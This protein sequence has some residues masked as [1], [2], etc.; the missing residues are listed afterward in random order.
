M[1]STT[2]TRQP[3]WLRCEKKEFERRAALTPTTA[4]KLIDAGFD[5]T[6]ERDPQRIF[7]DE[8]YE[9]VG[10]K[11]VDNNTWPTA[12][13][14]IPIIG[15]K[16]LPVSTDPLPHTH[17]QFAHCYKNQAGWAA[18]LT[19]FA[20]GGGTLYDLE[21][22]QD[23][24]G[25]RVAAFGFHAGFA[26]AAA[27]AL[28]LAD[29]KTNSTSGPL[30]GLKLEPYNNEHEMVADVKEKLSKVKNADGSPYKPKA[31]VI[32]ALGRCGRGAVELF[33]KIGLEEDDIFKWDLPETAK[34]GPFEEILQV[35]MFINC[36][37]L[38]SSIP[39]F[40]T[41]DTIRAAGPNRRLSVIADVSCDTTNPFNP[42]PVYN[43]MTT[44]DAPTVEVDVGLLNLSPQ[45]P[46]T[47][48]SKTPV[49]SSLSPTMSAVILPPTPTIEIH[50][51][52]DEISQQ[53]EIKPLRSPY[54][55][56]S[57]SPMA[58]QNSDADDFRPLHLLPPPVVSP[59]KEH[60][61]SKPQSAGLPT[62]KKGIDQERFAQLL[63]S[64]RERA[65]MKHGRKESVE[66]RKQVTLKVHTTKAL[67]RRAL[68][69][70]KIQA[71]PNPEAA[72]S[73]VTPP[74]SPAIFHFTLPSPGMHSP[75]AMFEKLSSESDKGC[76][77]VNFPRDSSAPQDAKKGWVEEV[78][79][80]ARVRS[81]GMLRGSSA[82]ASL[83][84][85]VSARSAPRKPRGSSSHALPSL[86][87]ITARLAT[88]VA[89]HANAAPSDVAPSISAVGGLKPRPLSLVV[90][91]PRPSQ[92][93]HRRTPSSPLATSPVFTPN[94]KE[95]EEKT[96]EPESVPEI[97]VE[98][99]AAAPSRLPPFLQKRISRERIEV[100]SP[101]PAP[102]PTPAPVPAPAPAPETPTIQVTEPSPVQ[103]R[104]SQTLPSGSIVLQSP[105]VG[106]RRTSNPP[107]PQLPPPQPF[108]A[109]LTPTRLSYPNAGAAP[110]S[111][112]TRKQRGLD[113]VE[114]LRRRSSAPAALPPID[115]SKQ[116]RV[117]SLKGGF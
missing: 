19:R 98:K 108:A 21:F 106:R 10:C 49:A 26:G 112:E 13:T 107:P 22:L 85:A 38:S 99:P 91:R 32:G 6:V 30:K 73:P 27:A 75:L 50:L 113:M 58:Y 97:V 4:R 9:K 79:F 62:D 52:D 68:F 16:E 28:A 39:P 57:P 53:L 93:G 59:L 23:E 72:E 18:V 51:A 17:I 115:K 20:R 31:L 41:L 3:L 70:S 54:S 11:L 12:P 67:E 46:P 5:I 29:R 110:V 40:I 96:P 94:V 43:V 47:S 33:R 44:F 109:R 45:T 55:P 95:E 90:A 92:L 35:D 101:A 87:Q 42:I 61:L 71:A 25:R 102:A 82:A 74:E 84:L 14:E 2:S 48:I 24:S 104:S 34:G 80:K 1:S 63:K 36:I 86:D 64:S 88:K 60:R 76:N 66:L 8:E 83:D 65:A 114:K 78:D 77:S 103:K 69:L 105:P 56:K 37:Y 15:L 89:A 111:S 81:N 100:P 116:H 117:L 7:D